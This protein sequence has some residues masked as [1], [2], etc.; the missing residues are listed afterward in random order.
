MNTQKDI[1]GGE[2]KRINKL[3]NLKEMRKCVN[4]YVKHAIYHEYYNE[5]VIYLI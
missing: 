1:V 4:E 3:N 2:T 5:N